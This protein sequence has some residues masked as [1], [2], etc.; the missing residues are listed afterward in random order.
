MFCIFSVKF[1]S[2][3]FILKNNIFGMQKIHGAFTKKSRS[4][5]ANNSWNYFYKKFTAAF[6]KKFT[7]PNPG[8]AAAQ[9]SGRLPPSLAIADLQRRTELC[10]AVKATTGLRTLH[11]EPIPKNLGPTTKVAHIAKA[12]TRAVMV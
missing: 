8:P 2:L 3:I 1:L 7:A 9:R 12:M 11:L 4:V 6:Y 10:I 5:F